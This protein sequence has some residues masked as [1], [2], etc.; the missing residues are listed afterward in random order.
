MNLI[1]RS[2]HVIQDSWH[3]LDFLKLSLSVNAISSALSA[4]S[5]PSTLDFSAIQE[6][7]SALV[8]ELGLGPG[9]L[10]SEIVDELPDALIH[11][12][13]EWDAE[14]RLGDDICFAE[15][16]FLGERK[17]HMKPY[18]A[19][20]FGVSEQEIDER[21]LPIVAIAGSGGGYRAMLNTTGSLIGAQRNG[22]FPCVSYTA[23]VSGSHD[24]SDAAEHIKS[25]IQTSYLDTDTL[26]ALTTAPTNK[27]L[28]SGIL[29][30]AA[31]TSGVASLVDVYGTLLASRL[32]VPDNLNNLNFRH[33]SLHLSRQNIDTGR[34]PL[35]IYTAIQQATPPATL[36][37]IREI[38]SEREHSIDENQRYILG[39]AQ[40]RLEDEKRCLWYEFTPF[41]VGCDEIGAW[42]PSWSLGRPFLNGKNTERRPELSMTILTGIFGSAFCASLKHYFQE[43]QPTLRLLPF[44][45]YNWLEDI[46]TENERDLGLIHPVLPDQLPN[47]LK[48]LCGQLRDGSPY[49][50]TDRE[51]MTF[52]DAGAELNL[53]YYPLLRRDVDCI[54]ALD[55]SADSQDLWFTRAEQLAAKRGLRTWPKGAGWP[56]AVQSTQHS[57]KDT[58]PIRSDADAANLKLA[59]TQESALAEQTAKQESTE[60][61]DIPKASASNGPTHGQGVSLNACEVWIGS[62]KSAEGESSRLDDLDEDTLRECDGIGVVY[63]PLGPNEKQV[64]GFDPSTISTWRREVTLTESQALLDVAEA[65]FSDSAEKITRLLRAIW[66]RKKH[67]REKHE[68]DIAWKNR[69]DGFHKHLRKSF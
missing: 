40:S 58:P 57:G 12:E 14:V 32:F 67:E 23:G 48:G 41:E 52:M 31:G 2:P 35:P 60:D 3:G 42:I 5:W 34:L 65:N 61:R 63:I 66:Y 47:F 25:R 22:I 9:S 26:D 64:P 15:R 54:I 44:Q 62:S 19:K 13:V 50:L 20:L 49:D 46:A 4:W 7:V 43:I 8:L 51:Y 37:T 45:L 27:Y 21:D 30:K 33:L 6:K 18:F 10:Y 36:Q 24:P 69:L 11:P 38:T 17:R 68:W 28:L 16:A 59:E 53:P 55:A 29:R 56:T 39:Q 1:S